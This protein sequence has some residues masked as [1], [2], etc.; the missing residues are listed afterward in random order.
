M[1][2]KQ[3]PGGE[4]F[5]RPNPEATGDTYDHSHEILYHKDL[6]FR[7]TCGIA[8]GTGYRVGDEV[9]HVLVPGQHPVIEIGLLV[10]KAGDNY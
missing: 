3:S 6:E 1:I 8:Q 9:A 10:E 2:E 7:P 5:T 4:S